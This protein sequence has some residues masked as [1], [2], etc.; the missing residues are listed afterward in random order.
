TAGDVLPFRTTAELDGSG[1]VLELLA[2]AFVGHIE[3]KHGCTPFRRESPKHQETAGGRTTVILLPTVSCLQPAVYSLLRRQGRGRDRKPTP[4]CRNGR[5]CSSKQR[6]GTGRRGDS[7][8]L[9]GS[10]REE[11]QSPPVNS[12]AISTT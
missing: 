1:D 6:R 7:D 4:R 8:S 11:D 9:L 5:C 12:K 10:S 3:P 2:F